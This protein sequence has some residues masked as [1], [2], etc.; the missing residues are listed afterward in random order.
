MDPN[1]V[2]S[3]A[4]A[5]TANPARLKAA[6]TKAKSKFCGI[7]L[8]MLQ[9]RRLAFAAFDL[10]PIQMQIRFTATAPA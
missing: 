4:H 8:L 7:A 1:C 6:A 5:F 9:L 2:R 10:C 3:T